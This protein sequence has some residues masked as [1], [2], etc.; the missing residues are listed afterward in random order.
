MNKIIYRKSIMILWIILEVIFAVATAVLSVKKTSFVNT[1]VIIDDNFLND[2]VQYELYNT[3]QLVTLSILIF[4]A[5]GLIFYCI[6]LRLTLKDKYIK[7][8]DRSLLIG[9]IGIPLAG[10]VCFGILPLSTFPERLNEPPKVQ[11]EN[12]VH[13][14]TISTKSGK[15]YY[16]RFGNGSEIEVSRT[17]YNSTFINQSHYT[18]YQ[19]K[20]L[21]E[22]FPASRYVLAP[23][24]P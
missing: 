5:A 19:G 7:K 16:L 12:V 15:D 6:G 10:F 2:L 8:R 14:Y 20:V 13:K 18:V 24:Q 4:F 21:I 22:A 11:T 17:T 1:G 9:V 23:K 3:A